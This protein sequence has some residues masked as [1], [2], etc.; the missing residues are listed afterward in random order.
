MNMKL[1]ARLGFGKCFER[2]PSAVLETEA[3]C[4]ALD[5]EE[6]FGTGLSRSSQPLLSKT[7]MFS[8]LGAGVRLVDRYKLHF[9]YLG[10]FIL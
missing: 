4:Q 5:R 1:T 7:K 2:H 8:N 3:A 10:A 9:T 6:I